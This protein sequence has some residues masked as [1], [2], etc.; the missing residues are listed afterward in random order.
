MDARRRFLIAHRLIAL[1]LFAGSL[2]LYIATLAPTVVTIFDDS[3]EFQLVP[4]LLGVAHPTGYPL[5]TLLGKAFTLLPVGDI[6]YRINLLSAVCAAGTVAALYLL[7]TQI[8]GRPL[9]GALSA[10]FLALSPV[11]WSQATIAEVYTLHTLL[12]TLLFLALAHWES[13]TGGRQAGLLCAAL[14]FG[15]GLAHHRTIL[16][17]V[18]GAA[19][20]VFLD[21]HRARRS[22][23][24]PVRPALWKLALAILLPLALYA[25]IPLVGARVGSLDGTYSNTWAGFWR[26]VLALDYSAF[27]TG[28]PL[29]QSRDAAFYWN[30]W[31]TQFGLVGGAA[32]L[33]G[34]FVPWHR[35]RLGWAL[36]LTGL[37]HLL[38]GVLY[39]VADVEVFLLPA[40][41]VGASSIG[42]LLDSIIRLIP[43]AEGRRGARP[44]VTALL[45]A[46]LLGQVLLIGAHNYSGADRSDDWEVHDWAVLALESDL[47]QGAA[48]IGI[49]GETTVLR[50]FQIA[51]GLRPDLR[52]IPADREEARWQA[53]EQAVA[54][55]GVAVLTRGMAGLESAYHL[56]ALGPLVRV[57]PKPAGPAET[58][59]G[60]EELIPGLCLEDATLTLRVMPGRWHVIAELAWRAVDVALPDA[61]LSLRVYS[62]SGEMLAQHDR[63]PVHEAYPTGAWT[64]GETVRD[65]HDVA[66][67]PDAPA[68][69]YDIVLI[70]YDPA[71]G[72]EWVRRTLGQVSIPAH[73]AREGEDA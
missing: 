36:K 32:A 60:G 5:Y 53:M 13:G 11:F 46:L 14:L 9:A 17:A 51:H 24:E 6:A 7:G 28:N 65:W 27:L 41:L 1:L 3:P 22:G 69:T 21:W 10:A 35:R 12:L 61:R 48:V 62:A 29:G 63:R 31:T 33:A 4:Y 16:L 71:D 20:L 45:A 68:G 40:F 54:E 47:P 49:L 34:L 37:V 56:D 64:R 2:G 23:G 55:G 72:T 19:I 58:T 38:F 70:V 66:L 42:A 50:Y 39:H 57:T 52:F 59:C 18:P 25:Y 44:A 8:T 73:P 15:L 26:H 30:L 43:A 67:P